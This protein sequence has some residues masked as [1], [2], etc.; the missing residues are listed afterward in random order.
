MINNIVQS[1]A[2]DHKWRCWNQIRIKPAGWYYSWDR[3]KCFATI[4]LCGSQ[5]L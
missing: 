1:C 5:V 2:W 4:P 3:T